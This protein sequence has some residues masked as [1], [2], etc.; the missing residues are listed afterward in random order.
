M[1]LEVIFTNKKEGM[2]QNNMPKQHKKRL[3]HYCE[4]CKNYFKVQPSAWQLKHMQQLNIDTWIKAKQCDECE[5]K[6]KDDAR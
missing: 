1:I 3:L 4:G 2:M 5:K 6:E